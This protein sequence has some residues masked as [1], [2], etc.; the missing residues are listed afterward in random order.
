MKNMNI[1][2]YE[3]Y[4]ENILHGEMIFPY[5]TYLCSIPLDFPGV[6]LHW[7]DELELIYVKKGQGI[8]TVDF[9]VYDVKAPSLLLILPRQ[10]HSIEQKGTF[11]IEYENIIFHPSLLLSR[12][13]DVTATDFLLPLIDGQ[14]T[15][16]TLFTPVYPYYT[17]VIAPIDAC[18]EIGKTRPQ[19][20]ELFIK[21]QLYYFF[22]ILNNRCRNLTAPKSN[23]KALEKMKL[24]LKYIENHYMEKITIAE[25]AATVD[26]SESHFMRYFKETMGISFVGYLKDYRLTMAARLL[27]SS[28]SSVLDIAA[29]VGFDNLSYFNRAFKEK[30]RMTPRQFRKND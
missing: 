9:K 24:V 20:Y 21:S 11:S 8:I 5:N 7:H 1:L 30:Y 26:F 10:L 15:V 25:I 19:G 17:D 12:Q 18:D 14:I 29:E 3:N 22:F 13:T 6:P 2:E 4:H 16:P 28:D 23:Y 27:T